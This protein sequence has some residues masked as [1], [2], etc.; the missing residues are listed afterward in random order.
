MNVFCI[1]GKESWIPPPGK[2]KP[3]NLI[4][5]KQPPLQMPRAKATIIFP[6]TQSFKESSFVIMLI[7][8]AKDEVLYIPKLKS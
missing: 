6:Q 7:F 1:P 8:K 4:W 5:E 2:G 3:P